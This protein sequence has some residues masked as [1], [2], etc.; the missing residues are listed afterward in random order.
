MTGQLPRAGEVRCLNRDIDTRTRD[1]REI[2]ANKG[3]AALLMPRATFRRVAYRHIDPRQ[4]ELTIGSPAHAALAA[5][6]AAVFLVSKQAA[7]IRLE[8]IGLATPAGVS[9]LPGK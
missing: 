4:G 1:W 7:A 5:D 2:Q 3:M 9:I 8:T 6:L